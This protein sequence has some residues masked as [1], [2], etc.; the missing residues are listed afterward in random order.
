MLRGGYVT[1]LQSEGSWFDPTPSRLL[2]VLQEKEIKTFYVYLSLF[3]LY[4]YFFI[5]F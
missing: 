1:D 4:I 2:K 3:F 5:F